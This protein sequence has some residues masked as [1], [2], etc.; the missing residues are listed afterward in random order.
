MNIWVDAQLSPA[1]AEWIAAEFEVEVEHL[2]TLDLVGAT[3]GAVFEK[4][5]V[6]PSSTL[7]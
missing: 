3:D 6:A 1:L 2:N 5:R 4:A 7:I